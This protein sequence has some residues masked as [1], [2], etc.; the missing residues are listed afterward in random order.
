MVISVISILN[1]STLIIE[2][3]VYAEP[4]IDTLNVNDSATAIEFNSVNEEMFVVG[5]GN[6]S[7][8]PPERVLYLP[9]N[10]LLYVSNNNGSI[11]VINPITNTVKKIINIGPTAYLSALEFV[12]Y[13]N[14]IYVYGSYKIYEIDVVA[15]TVVNN[16]ITMP[17]DNYDIV[18]S[19]VNN[20]LYV[21]SLTSG[22]VI[23][24]DTFNNT[25][26]KTIRVGSFPAGIEFVPSISKLFV[27]NSN[28]KSISVIDTKTN[29][30]TSI[31]KNVGN[32]PLKVIYLPQNNLLY[33]SLFGDS[34]VIAI[35]PISNKVVA[36]ISVGLSPSDMIFDSNNQ[37]FVANYN[38]KSISVID[39]KT[40]TIKHTIKNIGNTPRF[41]EF[42]PTNNM[43][44]IIDYYGNRV[45]NIS[46]EFLQIRDTAEQGDEF[47][48]AAL[49]A[50]DFNK[51]GYS[52]LAIGVPGE[53]V[54]FGGENI[55][56]AGIINV[57][58]GSAFGLRSID[59]QIWYQGMHQ[60]NQQI[61][62]S[63]ESYD[64]FGSVLAAG[65]FNKDGYS[66]LAIGV[67]GED[68]KFGEENIENAGVISVIY[69]LSLGL[70]A[71]NNQIWHQGLN[72]TLET[73]EQNDGFG[74]ALAVGNFG[75]GNADDLAIGVAGEDIVN[76]RDA[77]IINIIYG[78]NHTEGLKAANNQIWHQGLNGTLE[79]A[80]Q[81]DG[82]GSAL[83]A[84]DFNNNGFDDLAIGV[85]GEDIVNKGSIG[86]INV[87]YGTE[88]GLKSTGN[89]I[90][91][92]GYNGI[93]KTEWGSKGFGRTLA[94]GNFDKGSTDDLVIGAPTG[95]N[96]G[97]INVI[98]GSPTGLTSTGNQIWYQGYNGIGDRP[99][100]IEDDR[101]PEQFGSALAVGNFGKGNTDDLAIGVPGEDFKDFSLFPNPDAGMIHVIYGSPTGLTSTGSEIWRQDFDRFFDFTKWPNDRF[102]SA[103]AAGD[104]N[105]TR[106]DDLAIGVPGEDQESK[107]EI[108][109]S[110]KTDIGVVKVSY[111]SSTGLNLNRNNIQ[112][113]SQDT[114]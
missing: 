73:A 63:P 105:N 111:G 99:D 39:T 27:A 32:K 22:K 106:F 108:A 40:N 35:N 56:S 49:V 74:S 47:G 81:N 16:N 53:D 84:G 67:P 23:V 36:T 5:K 112:L 91:Y 88:H 4:V 80:E 72:G 20:Y 43:L 6:I 12:P 25:I 51:D 3:I 30:V 60:G 42:V 90:W 95:I 9:T 17:G 28:N 62:D 113:W 86:I 100:Q 29:N 82:F 14:S 61:L 69:G 38:N 71:A 13:K 7:V 59:N 15:N 1:S 114:S 110:I 33:V 65:D 107:T 64:R 50:G 19:P 79:T 58:Y 94:A 21:T 48:N 76:K 44:Y 89:Q 52:D 8:A 55:R 24:I 109:T 68:V 26:V 34:K 37:L 93:L 101:L 96:F 54:K 75:H 102:G 57:I 97:T 98:Y 77:G 18:F 92:Q 78:S 2:Q 46:T 41:L 85:A 104:F 70:R 87:I 10:N 83:A 66:D 31:I 103:L 11:S 45:L